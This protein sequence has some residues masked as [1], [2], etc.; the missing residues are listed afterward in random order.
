MSFSFSLTRCELCPRRCG[1][2]R[3][4]NPGG[5]SGQGFC[6]APAAPRLA[7]AALH[8]WEEPCLSG[9]AADPAHGSGTVFFSHC[10][11]GCCFCQNHAIS[12]GGFG[13]NITVER[14]AEIFL[15]LQAQG[16]YNLNLVTATPYLPFVVQ[17]LQAVRGQLHIPVVY[18]TGGYE[19][20]EAV[21]A[22]A[23]YVDIWLTDL[24]FYDG[25]LAARL[26][27]AGDYFAAAA[28]A[29]QQMVRQT[30]AP[31]FGADGLLRR[32]VIVRQLVLPGQR[33]DSCAVLDWLANELPRG[34]FLLSLMSQ[35]TPAH[36]ACAMPGLNRRV[37][38]FEYKQVVQHALDLG[39]DAGYMQERSS[40]KEEYTPPF[41]LQ[42]V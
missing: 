39:L 25:A 28:A 7:R 11:L 37:S 13:Q 31:V 19:R 18:N 21:Q 32:G 29:A 26:C 17:A 40:A 4:R 15:Q 1:A 8:H 22:L 9:S 10:N 42:G 5:G 24:K 34:S 20:P 12:D 23:P 27:G 35:Y 14:L 41:D 38:T 2:D 33:A 3:T 30:G 36:R 6:R 16:A